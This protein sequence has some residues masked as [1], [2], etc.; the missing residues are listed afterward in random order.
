MLRHNPYNTSPPPLRRLVSFV[1]DIGRYNDAI[2][3]YDRALA[4]FP[5]HFKARF[6]RAFAMDKLD[7]VDDAI[8][9]YTQAL[10]LLDIVP[11]STSSIPSHHHHHNNK[12]HR[13]FV[14][15]N[16]GICLD[17]LGRLTAAIDDFTKAIDTHPHAHHII[18]STSNTDA[19]AP[20]THT[21]TTHANAL[22]DFYH[23]RGFALLK[24][25]HY[26]R[27]ITGKEHTLYCTDTCILANALISSLTNEF[28]SPIHSHRLS[29]RFGTPTDASAHCA[30]SATVQGSSAISQL[31]STLCYQKAVLMCCECT[32]L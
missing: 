21:N 2:T 8:E 20:T 9:E 3:H 29:S 30:L 25:T 16:R 4:L 17:R 5:R 19:N 18:S 11:S 14:H 12:I 6:N 32:Q 13:A 23:N 27:A 31:K 1:C 22:A 26:H 15:Y 10:Q 24:L 28:I 7:R